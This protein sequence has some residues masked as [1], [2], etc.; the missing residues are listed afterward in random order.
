MNDVGDE[1]YDTRGF[2]IVSDFSEQTSRTC[3]SAIFITRCHTS[4]LRCQEREEVSKD[5]EKRSNEERILCFI[6]MWSARLRVIF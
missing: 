5:R 6:R 3:E 2:D 4:W 1:I